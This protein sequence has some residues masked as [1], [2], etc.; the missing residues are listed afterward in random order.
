M[1]I[2]ETFIEIAASESEVWQVLT[3]VMPAD[4]VPFGIQRIEGD[5][6]AGGRLKLWS[7][8]DPKRAFSLKVAQFDAP[9]TMVWKGGMPFGL[10]TGTRTFSL[11]PSGDG[12]RFEMREVFDG[13]LSS[14]IVKSIPDLTPSFEKFAQTLKRKAE[15]DE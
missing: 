1:K 6:R 11:A 3:E 14:V 7:E 5:I 15:K 8:V 12:T 4:P 9:R 10:F 2:Y 13:P